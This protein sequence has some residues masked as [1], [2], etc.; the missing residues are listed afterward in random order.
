MN[1]IPALVVVTQRPRELTRAELKELKR[2]VV[3]SCPLRS[4][5]RCPS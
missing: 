1:K 3:D 2:V 5:Y 4:G